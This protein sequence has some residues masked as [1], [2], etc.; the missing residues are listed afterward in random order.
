MSLAS[1][2]LKHLVI[3]KYYNVP[4]SES[5]ISRQGNGKPRYVAPEGS[6]Q[7]N[8][9]FNV[10]H[11]AGIVS[12]VAAIGGTDEVL[13]GTDVVCANERIKND[14][15]Q[16]EQEGFFKWVDIHADVFAESELSH[17]KLFPLD[18][19][20]GAD[21]MS[22]AGSGRDTI[23]RCQWRNQT[24]HLSGYD[25]SGDS[26]SSS[27]W[28]NDVIDAKLR[29]FYA[30][31]C[32]REAFV[33]MTGEALLAPWLKELEIMVRQAPIAG[34]EHG[35]STSFEVGNRL[36]IGAEPVGSTS[37]FSSRLP[38]TD[39]YMKGMKVTDVQMDITAY[40]EA[41]MVAAAVRFPKVC[42]SINE[43]LRNWEI[44]DLD[45]DILEVAE[46]AR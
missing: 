19:R 15:D 10:S 26:T 4:W 12:L 5:T 42:Q 1:H 34:A 31:W 7:P 21:V 33:K 44:L 45:R 35:D 16:I 24:I 39:I 22:I 14:Y 46:A 41:Y 2:L 37:K 29:R 3:T 9:D 13:V 11:Q 27:I 8:F 28:S 38:P 23:S 17:M 25:E 30:M 36:L 20:G 18:V 32:L 43:T 40:G 6:Q